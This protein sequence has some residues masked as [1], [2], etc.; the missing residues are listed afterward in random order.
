LASLIVR[1]SW[2]QA[3]LFGGYYDDYGRSLNGIV[4]HEG[5]NMLLLTGTSLACII[6][7]GYAFPTSQKPVVL[8]NYEGEGI[9]APGIASGVGSLQGRFL[10]I[11]GNIL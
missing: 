5:Q 11:S 2:L 3:H 1:V 9:T 6:Q 8:P 7:F 10:Q 4:L